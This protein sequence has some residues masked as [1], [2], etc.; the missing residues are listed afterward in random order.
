MMMQGGTLL[1]FSRNLSY[2]G[3]VGWKIAFIADETE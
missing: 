3:A 1:G 2:L